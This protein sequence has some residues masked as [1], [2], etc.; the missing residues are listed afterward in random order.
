MTSVPPDPTLVRFDGPWR[1]FDVRAN[2]LRFHAVET[3]R[4]VADRPLVLL[5][6]GFAEFWWSWRHQLAALT[7]AGY[8]AVAVDLRGYGDSDKPP[9]GYDGWTLAG[10]TNA[11]IRA[12]G[13]TN[14]TLVGHADGGL[15][16][17]ATATLHPAV[18]DRVAVV[19]SPHPRALKQ[20]VLFNSEERSAFLAP[21]LHNQLPRI[22]ERRLTRG[23]GAFVDEYFRERSGAHWRTTGDFA[24][25]VSRNRLAIQIPGVAHCSLEY[26]RWAFRSQFRNDGWRFMDLMDERL[27][28]PLLAVRGHD[29]AYI[30]DSLMAGS[31]RWAADMDY[32]TITGAGHFAHQET[33]DEFNAM[34]LELLER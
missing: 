8:R 25:A 28:V 18:V 34:L 21:F 11:L 6:H 7:E 16:C 5:L 19:S 20:G 32:R 23:D 30:L 15:V 22:G 26:R 1:H 10:D 31:R 9:R 33:P 14:A 12:L 3:Q 27:E 4:F 2:G 17:W 29:D 13:H 24:E